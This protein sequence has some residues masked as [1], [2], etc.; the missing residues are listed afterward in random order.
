MYL[1]N[2]NSPEKPLHPCFFTVRQSD[3]RVHAVSCR[4]MRPEQI[5]QNFCG[6]Q[7]NIRGVVV[8]F[9]SRKDEIM[10][11][12]LSMELYVPHSWTLQRVLDEIQ[13]SV[14][15]FRVISLM[16]VFFFRGIK[17]PLNTMNSI[18]E[19]FKEY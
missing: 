8:E 17:F 11:P 9:W 14:D 5:V 16:N 18:H 15:D 1:N 7:M 19:K 12:L 10:R 4:V 3:F 6:C 13:E 2:I